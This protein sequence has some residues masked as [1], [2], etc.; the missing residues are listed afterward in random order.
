MHTQHM[1]RLL[2]REQHVVRQ[3]RQPSMQWEFDSHQSVLNGQVRELPEAAA[4]LQERSLPVSPFGKA[5]KNYA[6]G[7]G[8]FQTKA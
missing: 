5:V 8:C 6:A 7:F 3:L 2:Q 1:E 4:E